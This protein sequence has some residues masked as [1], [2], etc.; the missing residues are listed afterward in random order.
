MQINILTVWTRK[1]ITTRS[2]KTE[3]NICIR[4]C[5][6]M[7]S[8]DNL[9][10]FQGDIFIVKEYHPAQVHLHVRMDCS[11]ILDQDKYCINKG[12]LPK[13]MHRTICY[14]QH[15]FDLLLLLDAV[16]KFWWLWREALVVGWKCSCFMHK[17]KT[18]IVSSLA[19][20]LL[21][22]L[23]IKPTVTRPR[24]WSRHVK[25]TMSCSAN[26]VWPSTIENR[27]FRLI[28]GNDKAMHML[29]FSGTFRFLCVSPHVFLFFSIC[30]AN[31]IYMH[32][33]I[34][35]L[36]FLVCQ[37]RKILWVCFLWKHI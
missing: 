31:F 10:T 34:E 19:K 21:L 33:Y 2:L 25:V 32:G 14:V 5:L 37:S 27:S 17:R 30:V 12:Q 8:N 13:F 4:A 29:P 16:H 24:K 15:R 7:R 26:V 20:S 11:G 1:K 36:V 35:N 6:L 28:S 9:I 22:F 3:I 18:E 23:Y